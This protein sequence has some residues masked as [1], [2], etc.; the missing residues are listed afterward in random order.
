MC[1]LYLRRNQ[2][3]GT[4][5]RVIIDHRSLRAGESLVITWQAYIMSTSMHTWHLHACVKVTCL[6]VLFVIAW[7]PLEAAPGIDVDRLSVGWGSLLPNNLP[8]HVL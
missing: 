3:N 8:D 5:D 7:R 2:R 6:A 4:R 1:Y